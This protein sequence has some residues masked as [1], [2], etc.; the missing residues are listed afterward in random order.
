MKYMNFKEKRL[1][2][3]KN[4]SLLKDFYLNVFK[5]IIADYSLFSESTDSKLS[6]LVEYYQCLTSLLKG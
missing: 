4:K 6:K 2:V 5:N 3:Y 1:V